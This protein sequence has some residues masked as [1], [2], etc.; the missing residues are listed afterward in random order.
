MIEKI[1]DLFNQMYNL[2]SSV[3]KETVVHVSDFIDMI[4]NSQ[5]FTIWDE[6]D[7]F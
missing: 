2:F 6:V 3:L 4:S 1:L 5:K 7:D